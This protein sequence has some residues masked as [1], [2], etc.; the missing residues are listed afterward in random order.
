MAVEASPFDHDDYDNLGCE[1]LHSGFLRV[2]RYT[3]RHRLF[4]G[5][6][7]EAFTREILERN[8][9]VG[10]LLYDPDLDKVV[11]VEQF[12]AGCLGNSAGPWVLELVAGIIDT[13]ESPEEVARREAR[14]EA[15]LEVTTLIP[16]CDYYNSPG[17]SSEHL[18]IVCAHADA[19]QAGGVHGLDHEHEDIRTV[20]LDRQEAMAAI[21]TGRINNAM[22]IIALQWLALNLKQVCKQLGR[23]GQV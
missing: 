10:V 17:G 11:L 8:P 6:W 12:R 15:G 5:G 2:S 20:V 4:E 9:G 14:E 22:A 18:S 19:L 16:V 13:N 23:A 1:T 3:L 7:S 21:A